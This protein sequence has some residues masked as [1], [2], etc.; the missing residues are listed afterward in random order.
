MFVNNK[1]VAAFTALLL[2]ASCTTQ[3]DIP[4]TDRKKSPEKSTASPG[5]APNNAPIVNAFS[6]RPSNRITKPDD[7]ITLNIV[8]TDADGDPLTYTWST[9]EGK[10]SATAG[11]SVNWSPAFESHQVESGLETLSAT[12]TVSVSDGNDTTQ[13]SV[14][15]FF[16]AHLS[17][18]EMPQAQPTPNDN[19]FIPILLPRPTPTPENPSG[20]SATPTPTA[21]Q[22]FGSGFFN[23]YVY[24][25][26]GAPLADVTLSARS[27]NSSV[28]YTAE[29]TTAPDGSYSFSRA[30]EGIQIEITA[31]RTGYSTRR[32]IEVIKSNKQGDPDAN[33]YDFSAFDAL[34][35]KPEVTRVIPGR[36]ASGVSPSP[37]FVLTF[38]EP[39]DRQSVTN[40]FEIR[41]FGTDEQLSVDNKITFMAG[42]ALNGLLTEPGDLIWDHTAFNARWNRDDTEVTLRFKAGK[43]LPSDHDSDNIPDY[44]VSFKAGTASIKDKTGVSR[45]QAHFKLTDGR[46]ENYFKF[47][48]NT[49]EDRPA[50]DSVI[51]ID[52]NTPDNTLGDL[53]KVRFSEPMIYPTLSGPVAGGING[54]ASEAVDV[55]ANYSININDGNRVFSW[56]QAGAGHT[57]IAIFDTNDPTHRTLLLLT[58]NNDEDIFTASDQIKVTVR[59]TVT[60]PAGNSMNDL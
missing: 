24:D 7:K 42:Q 37:R 56:D 58:S 9:T 33:R 21:T 11:S 28:A 39:M 53:I 18:A 32:R 38:S 13:K 15:V 49:D 20:E 29:T 59:S 41:T 36:N 52:G 30:P 31:N 14:S 51:V 12:I 46:F 60:D 4:G 47:S 45:D 50:L 3:A 40:A 23:G 25:D 35:N 19:R 44:S 54:E 57:G 17:S 34:S 10:L 26:S 48:I 5:V 16:P 55:A 1:R 27:L 2:M 8:A 43:A 22:Y 6:I